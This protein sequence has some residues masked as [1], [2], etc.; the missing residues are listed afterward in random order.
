MRKLSDLTDEEL[1]AANAELV[2]RRREAD[3]VAGYL[4]SEAHAL[5]EA[6]DDELDALPP[7]EAEYVRA[8]RSRMESV[9]TPLPTQPPGWI[10]TLIAVLKYVP[11]RMSVSM[12]SQKKPSTKR[13]KQEIDPALRQLRCLLLERTGW[14][15]P[16]IDLSVEREQGKERANGWMALRLVDP[17]ASDAAHHVRIEVIADGFEWEDSGAVTEFTP[18][19]VSREFS[20]SS[21]T[22]ELFIQVS[23]VERTPEL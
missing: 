13:K 7:E 12:G 5:L 6:T 19:I 3:R 18:R 15:E 23:V 21:K 11:A 17:T 2:E 14:C 10:E 1:A 4:Y 9:E 16:T 22:T 20:L 8:Y